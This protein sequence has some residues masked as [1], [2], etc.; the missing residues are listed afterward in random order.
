VI[1]YLQ[2]N[3]AVPETKIHS[4]CKTIIP[5]PPKETMAEEAY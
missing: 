1:S 5:E 2:T 3:H 4:S